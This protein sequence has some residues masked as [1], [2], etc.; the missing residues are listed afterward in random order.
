MALASNYIKGFEHSRDGALFPALCSQSQ[1]LTTMPASGRH[2]ALWVIPW[3]VS[4]IYGCPTS[5][6]PSIIKCL[7]FLLENHSLTSIR[8]VLRV[9]G[10]NFVKFL[11]YSLAQLILI[12]MIANIT[13]YWEFTKHPWNRIA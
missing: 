11:K 4:V 8:V 3:W 5:I 6:S 10:A 7:S 13:L 12:I 1:C 9:K 2:M